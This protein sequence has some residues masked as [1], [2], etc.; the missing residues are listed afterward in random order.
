MF[1]FKSL[2]CVLMLAAPA[3]FARD[4]FVRDGASGG[5]GSLAKPFNDPWQAL[6]VC[7]AN[8]AIHVAAGKYFGRSKAGYWVIPFDGVQLIGGYDKDFKSRDPWKNLTELLWDKASKNWPKEERISSNSQRVVIDG[9]VIDMREQDEYNEPEQLGRKVDRPA[10][11]AVRFSR[12]VTIRNSVILN[13]GN[14][15]ITA[16]QGSTIENNLVLNAL[17]WGVVI[18]MSSNE[19]NALAT[20]KNN[21][22]VF[23]QDPK[24]AGTGRYHGAALAI[25][26]P[27][28]ISG[29]ILANS[30]NNAIYMTTNPE[31]VSITN[32][33][34][35]M[36]LFSN[37]KFAID[38]K[39]TEIDDKGMDSLDEVGLKASEG[40][41]VKNPGLELDP[42]WLD[43]YSKRTASKP[44][45]LVMNDWNQARQALGL[46]LMG[47][48]GESASGVCPAYDLD[49]ALKLMKPKSSKAGA[50]VAKLEVK[51]QGATEA[52]PSR[53]YSRV[54]A[55]SFTKSPGASDGKPVEM[56]VAIG[57]A[58]ANVSGIPSAYK[59]DECAGAVLYEPT[60]DH[61]RLLGF[62]KKG[63]SAQ[64]F[65]EDNAGLYTGTGAPGKVFVAR[66][67][68]YQMKGLPKAGLFIESIE[69]SEAGAGPPAAAGT[70]NRPVGRDWFVRAGATN[71]DGSKEK[72]FKDPWQALEK[73]ESGD[74]VHVAEGEYF[75]KL[76]TGKWKIDTTYIAL[77]GGYDK[78]FTERNPWKHPTRLYTPADY[79]GDRDGY[80]I[81]GSS[82]HTGAIVD[83]FV[84]DKKLNN[85]YVAD[86][87]LNYSN[88][89]D[90]KEH[91]WFAKPGCIIRNSVFLNGDEG[92]LRVTG[93][94]TVENNIFIN[95]AYRTVKVERGFGGTTII[96]K[97]TMLFAWDPIRFG[98]GHGASG[99]LLA[100]EGGSSSIVDA[101]IF[102]FA[103][104]D[105]IRMAAEAKDVELTNNTFAKNL[106][107]NV[108]RV[109][110]WTA[111]DDKE[112]SQLADLKFKKLSGNTLVEAA[113]PLDQAWFEVYLSRVAPVPGKV[114]M[115]DWNQLREVLGQP[116]IATGSK[117]GSGFA[118]AY[119]W[120]KALLLFPKNAK[121]TAGARASTFPVKFSGVS[122]AA[123]AA[124]NW[125]ETSW[126]VAK[127]RNSWDAMDGKHVAMK[128]VI[129]DPDN[130]Y[131]LDDIK[132][133]EYQA[134]TICGPEGIDSGG[135]PMR[136]YVKR[137]TK[138]ERVL[139]NA[140]S[141]SSG[142]PAQTYI[143]KGVVRTNRQLVIEAMERAD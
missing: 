80:T 123:E 86:G 63:S 140:K 17:G 38:S 87:D 12:A 141:Y 5:D 136:A 45:K 56:I 95:H 2:L 127:N 51:F 9:V 138:W 133:G 25:K 126:D 88:S 102:E 79:K 81:E 18:N 52:A 4:W 109:T 30:D 16:V 3:A 115:D 71:G 22:I 99:Y 106:W 134:F 74:S 117:G 24:E 47:T 112:W 40:N 143:V 37:L 89:P 65:V 36:N 122:K 43:R 101:N 55:S 26:G 128:V 90:K 72:P 108:Q 11:D 28:V 29:N 61:N 27:A 48:G 116:V 105:A 142:P 91:I 121:V 20:V 64:R 7:E 35:F 50:R 131:Q 73:V 137:G 53:E 62:Y 60:G 10:E 94:Q 46:P 135:L 31:K 130:Q 68:A 76:K 118:P 119:D 125:D 13:P 113:L 84:F 83:G 78:D 110:D 34:F 111:V 100:L 57:T 107:S 114:K 124:G 39:E 85:V 21:T 69:L 14:N 8:D 98:T 66:G 32:N 93:G 23:S 58:G 1:K 6:D 70:S 15:G 42:K 49:K 54:D 92:A 41:E 120:Q 104:N 82:D 103:D 132:T 139:Q 75:G 59:P 19:N 67:V 33:T 44:G 77:I 96:R 129:R 97:N